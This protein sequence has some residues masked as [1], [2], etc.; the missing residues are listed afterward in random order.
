MVDVSSQLKG[1]QPIE[2]GTCAEYDNIPHYL[3]RVGVFVCWVRKQGA[4][5]EKVCF[6]VESPDIC[7]ERLL[8]L[9]QQLFNPAAKKLT[10]YDKVG[11]GTFH[12]PVIY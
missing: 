9:T 10:N 8:L 4:G 6:P 3:C 2:D 1:K 11:I 5:S 7:E 12:Y